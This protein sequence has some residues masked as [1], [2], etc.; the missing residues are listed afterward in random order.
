MNIGEERQE[1]VGGRF[2]VEVDIIRSSRTGIENF[3]N[4]C[5]IGRVGAK[6]GVGEGLGRKRHPFIS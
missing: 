5:N 3:L 1:G 2:H 6:A 4:V